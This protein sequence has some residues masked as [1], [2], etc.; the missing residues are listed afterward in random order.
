MNYVNY[1]IF[2]NDS[3]FTLRTYVKMDLTGT[4]VRN[5]II[6]K[7]DRTTEVT[8]ACTI[9]PSDP[10]YMTCTVPTGT[11]NSVG[12]YLIKSYIE[13]G[14]FKKYGKTI[15]IEIKSKWD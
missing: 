15:Q 3:G 5:L 6:Q 7:P 8:I 1:E 11:F 12:Y 14:A 2:L 9:D 13:K 4:S 10:K